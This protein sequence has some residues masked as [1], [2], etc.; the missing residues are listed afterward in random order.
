VRVL[1]LTSRVP[2]PP[3]RGDKVRTCNFLRA[4]AEGHEVDLLTFA[5]G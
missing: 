1:A 2:F 4:L 5:E 3:L